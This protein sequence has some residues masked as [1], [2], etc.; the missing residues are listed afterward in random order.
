MFLKLVSEFEIHIYKGK[1]EHEV[2]SNYI[3]KSFYQIPKD[4]VLVYLN[5]RTQ[6]KTIMESN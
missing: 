5:E 6:E 3:K 1:L 2:I 4:F